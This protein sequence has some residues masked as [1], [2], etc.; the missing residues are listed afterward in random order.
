M[1]NFGFFIGVMVENLFDLL[2]VNFI[3]GI[4]IFMGFMYGFLLVDIEEKL[5]L[6]F[7]RGKRLIV[8]YV[9]N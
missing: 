4:K 2:I 9:E 8:V 5:E 7:V 1:V 6:I 3:F